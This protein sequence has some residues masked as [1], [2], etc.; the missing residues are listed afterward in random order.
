MP[1]RVFI[2]C[3]TKKDAEQEA[4]KKLQEYFEDRGFSVY[5]VNR[6]QGLY[7]SESILEELAYSDYFLFVDFYRDREYEEDLPISL[8]SHQELAVATVEGFKYDIACFRDAR[9]E[10]RSQGL[11][12]YLQAQPDTFEDASDLMSLVE[13]RTADWFPSYSRH[14]LLKGISRVHPE[15]YTDHMG[16]YVDPTIWHAKV[17]NKRLRDAAV[18]CVCRVQDIKIISGGTAHFTDHANLKWA[19][20]RETYSVNLLPQEESY[21]DLLLVSNDNKIFLNSD[22]DIRERDG[23]RKPIIEEEGEYHISYL[24]FSQGFRPLR[25]TAKVEINTSTGVEIEI[26]DKTH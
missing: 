1:A 18:S 17:Q 7:D 22:S 13:E 2:S 3:G 5:K 6:Q 12:G 23:T 9:F 26:L 14:L 24:V 10:K 16:S 4:A 8:F 20:S 25:F 15:R 11:F 21:V 19:G